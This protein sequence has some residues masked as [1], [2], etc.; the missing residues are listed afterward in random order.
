[1]H[2]AVN[3]KQAFAA[4]GG[5]PL[6]NSLPAVLFLHGSGLDHTF[7]GLLARFFASHEY[8]ALV[9]DFPGHTNSNGP[10][11]ATIEETADWL[12]DAVAALSIDNISL[13]A[14]SQGCLTAL[15]FASRHQDRLKS[16][17]F[18]ASGLATPVN[19]DLI[20]AAENDPEAA[21]EMMLSWGFAAASH[22]HQGPLSGSS[23]FA[24]ART[25]I[26]RNAPD[27]LTTDLNACNNYQNGKTAA[28]GVDCPTQVL[29]GES[30]RMAPR[31]AGMELASHLPDPEVHIIK[32]CGHMVPLEAPNRCR[33]LLS[34]FIFTHNS[35]S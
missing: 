30:D 14:H 29:L 18:I 1:M 26:R 27:E 35:A 23:M 9:P 10:A 13:I 11:L 5:K 6:D 21:I 32:G 19:P 20:D 3:G 7:W 12:N 24:A 22:L 28:A 31:K 34:E 15:E 8:A 17:T 2:F 25:I 4:T 33:Q 16:V